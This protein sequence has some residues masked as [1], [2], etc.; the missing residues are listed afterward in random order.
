MTILICTASSRE[1]F[2]HA[3]IFL[4]T[5]PDSG[6]IVTALP[7]VSANEVIC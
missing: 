7:G 5:T 6:L 4:F 3:A 1:A 2:T